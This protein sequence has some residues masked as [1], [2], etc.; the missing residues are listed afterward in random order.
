M[1]ENLVDGL[2]EADVQHLVSFVQHYG[3]NMPDL[4]S[5]TPH[6][7]HQ[8]TGRSHNNV[9]IPAQSRQLEA[10]GLASVDRHDMKRRRNCP[11]RES[12]SLT[13]TA[14][15]P[16]RHQDQHLRFPNTSVDGLHQRNAPSGGLAGASLGLTNHISPRPHQ[17][18]YLL[19][20]GRR[21][22][23]SHLTQ[24]APHRRRDRPHAEPP[25]FFGPVF[26]GGSGWAGWVATLEGRTPTH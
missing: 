1:P 25:L 8:A 20:D 6:V 21:P 15:L 19:L 11:R 3:S 24:S 22:G 12:S 16:G 14:K 2:G 4:D 23:I 17:R 10:H 13:W 18:D 9:H 26:G 5:A 7:V